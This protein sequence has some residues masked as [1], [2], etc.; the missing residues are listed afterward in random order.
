MFIIIIYII[1]VNFQS[2][3]NRRCFFVSTYILS[4]KINIMLLSIPQSLNTI[5]YHI[6]T[7]LMY[8]IMLPSSSS[9]K[10]FKLAPCILQ[11]YFNL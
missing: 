2:Q 1:W 11:Y 10:L 4:I 6:K 3:V 9:T 7:F 5:F 8:L